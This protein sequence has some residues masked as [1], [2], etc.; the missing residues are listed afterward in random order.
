MT[1]ISFSFSVGQEVHIKPIDLDGLVTEVAF[2]GV[3]ELYTVRYFLSGKPEYVCFR[4]GD[5]E[6]KK[7]KGAALQ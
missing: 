5:L 3:K 7:E 6:P 2:D 4:C 1:Y